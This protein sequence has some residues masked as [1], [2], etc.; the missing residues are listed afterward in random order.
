MILKLE[1]VATPP[2]AGTVSV[3]E[4]VPPAGFVPIAIVTLFD[5]L[6]TVVPVASTIAT[7][8]VGDEIVPPAGAFG[9]CTWNCTAVAGPAPPSTAPTTVNAAL[10]AL[11][12]PALD[13][14][15]V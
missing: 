12:A 9:G 11:D 1:N 7:R 2:D 14:T 8:T 10:V 13:A 3:P 15:S 5:A 4:S 6:V